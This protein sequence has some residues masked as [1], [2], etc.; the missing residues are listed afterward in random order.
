[1]NK[2]VKDICST[3]GYGIFGVAVLLGVWVAGIH[4]TS[5]GIVLPGPGEVIH[6]FLVHIVV[7]IGKYTVFVHALKSLARVFTGYALSSVL[8]I[9]TGLAMGY[10]K[11][12]NAAVSPIFNMFRAIPGVAWIPL[13]IV[14]FGIG[15]SAKVFI[16]FVGGFSHIVLNSIAG[17]KRVSSE[18]IGAAQ[19]LGADKR[20][21]FI[22]VVLPSSIPYIFAGLQISL[23]GSWMSVVAAEM[24]SSYEG[25]GWIMVTGMNTGNTTQVLVGMISI[26]LIGL[27]LSSAMRGVERHLCAWNVRGR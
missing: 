24:I 6:S 2:K 26:A 3:V 12:V 27:I 9:I 7:P 21:V 18:L 5:L 13:A 11:S 17:A 23:S 22:K 14:W 15:E 4:F 20:Q 16:I 8:G 10:S 19:L 1:M 25:S